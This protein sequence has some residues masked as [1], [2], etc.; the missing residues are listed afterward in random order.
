MHVDELEVQAFVSFQRLPLFYC[1]L[2]HDTLVFCC[3]S[4]TSVFGVNAKE[5]NVDSAAQ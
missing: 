4:C 3:S 1:T 5:E 2:R